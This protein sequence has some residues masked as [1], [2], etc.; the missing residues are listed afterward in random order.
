MREIDSEVHRIISEQYEK[1]RHIL[2]TH[3]DQVEAMAAALLERETIDRDE[4]VL[5]VNGEPLPERVLKPAP[6]APA[7]GEDG[8][9]LP[10]D[11][12]ELAETVRRQREEEKRSRH[13]ADEPETPA[14]P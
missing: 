9:D 2:E 6:T 13:D 3:R 8:E 11:L 10:L 4:V 7:D 5:I 1:A 12:A 14:Q